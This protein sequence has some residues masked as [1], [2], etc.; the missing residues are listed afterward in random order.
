MSGNAMEAGAN[1]HVRLVLRGYLTPSLNRLLQK[2]WTVV[3]GEKQKALA[4]LDAALCECGSRA[5][6]RDCSTSTTLPGAANR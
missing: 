4:A 5:T 2:H 1:R 6:P 3:H